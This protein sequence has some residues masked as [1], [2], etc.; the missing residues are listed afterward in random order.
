MIT[1]DEDLALSRIER[2]LVEA[3]FGELGDLYIGDLGAD[4]GADVVD[5]GVGEKVGFS[6]VGAGARVGKL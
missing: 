4:V 6:R 3:F 1:E 5:L 2:E